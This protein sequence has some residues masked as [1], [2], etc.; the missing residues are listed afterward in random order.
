[1]KSTQVAGTEAILNW[2]GATIE[3]SPAP[4]MIVQPTIDI[5]ERF[6]PTRRRPNRLDHDFVGSPFRRS[7]GA[8][9]DPSVLRQRRRH[10][11]ADETVRTRQQNDG[12]PILHDISSCGFASSPWTR[13]A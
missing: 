10:V 7:H 9:H 6:V 8:P 2:L 11:S 4:M 3:D 1:M 12:L 13:A 5:G